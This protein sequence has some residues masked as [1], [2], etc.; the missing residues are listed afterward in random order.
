M[1]GL[2]EYM[3]RNVTIQDIAKALGVS[4]NTVSKVFN[5]GHS[6]PLSTRE[7]VICKAIEMNYRNMG[8]L[9]RLA[10]PENRSNGYFVLLSNTSLTDIIY[11]GNVIKG[12]ESQASAD[13]Y[14][15]LISTLHDRQ[16]ESLEIPR[17]LNDDNV[18]GIICL[19]L[20]NKQYLNSLLA[21]DIPVVFIDM[22]ADYN[23]LDG[24]F[25]VLIPQ[26]RSSIGAIVRRLTENGA[27]R[28]GFAGSKNHCLSFSE[29]FYGF[30]DTLFECGLPYDPRFSIIGS[31]SVFCD[32]NWANDFLGGMSELPDAII[33]AN[34]SLCA[35]IYFAAEKL[36]VR[37]PEQMI[38]T[39]FDNVSDS[40][41]GY[42]PQITV[43]VNRDLL[44]RRAAEQLV[45]R[46]LNPRSPNEIIHLETSP[47][48]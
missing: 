5:E 42:M 1:K 24:H 30:Y 39:G 40:R 11:W 9:S 41:Y 7:K 35:A 25:D 16:I 10:S 31:D 38:I 26:S 20:Y 14:T 12:I 19:E 28:I 34:D 36:G 47:I 13:G 46:V 32:I 33:C 37:V 45:K 43:D 3:G 4:R 29:R 23:T 15:L 21:L 44:G 48:F 17:A 6:I 27:K 8:S 22:I 18:S 2:N